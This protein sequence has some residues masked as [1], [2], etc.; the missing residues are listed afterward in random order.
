MAMHIIVA[1]TKE[2]V[3]GKDGSLP[4][5]IAEDMKLFRETTANKTVIMGKKTWFS[6]PQE[7]RPLP[8]RVNIIVSSTLPEQNGAM[9]CR[10]VQE[11]VDAARKQGEEVYCIGGAQ[12]YAAM[13]PMAQLLHISWVKK[14]YGGDTYFPKIDFSLWKVRETKEFDEF[15]YKMYVRR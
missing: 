7:H 5:K 9:V 13:L 12:L 4:W 10:T 15:T 14:S 1:M 11:A 6:L 3:I 2:R 8:D